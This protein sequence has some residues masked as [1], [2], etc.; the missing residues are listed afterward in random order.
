MNAKPSSWPK[1]AHR[2]MKVSKRSEDAAGTAWLISSVNYP[3]NLP[4]LTYKQYTKGKQ[5]GERKST[6]QTST[7]SLIIKCKKSDLGELSFTILL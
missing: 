1:F 5:Q 4:A 2:D 3:K 7:P 6:K